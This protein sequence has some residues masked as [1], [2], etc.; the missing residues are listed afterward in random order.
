MSIDH[1]AE[2][3]AR[4]DILTLVRQYVREV[5]QAGK[6]WK[7]LCPFHSEKTPSF[8]ISPD[9]GMAYC[10][11]CHKGGDIFKFIQD[12]ENCSFSEAL[13]ILADKSGVEIVRVSK[14]EIKKMKDEK[15]KVRAAHG[16]V[17]EFFECQLWDSKE[18]KKV[19]QYV[20]GRGVHEE[21]VKEFRLGYAPGGYED[22][23]PKLLKSGFVREDLVNAGLVVVKDTGAK[24]VY[25]RFRQRLMFPIEDAEG[26]IIGFGGRA[27]AAGVD[28]KYVNS[29]DTPV[30]HK[31]RVIYNLGRARAHVRE[32][33]SVIVVEGYMDVLMSHQAGVRNVVASSGTAFTGDQIK[34]LVRLTKNVYF[35]FDADFAG[36]E[37]LR[38]AIAISQDYDMNI[39]VIVIPKGKDP[40]DAVK[41]NPQLWVLAVSSALPYMDFYF[42]RVISTYDSKTPD[43]AR[44]ILAEIMPVLVRVKS[45]IELD[46]YVGQLADRLGVKAASVY[47][48]LKRS[49]SSDDMVR[50]PRNDSDSSGIV[51]ARD[52]RLTTDDYLFGLLLTSESAFEYFN[53]NFAD[54]P[55]IAVSIYKTIKDYYNVPSTD[56]STDLFL[57]LPEDMRDKAHIVALWVEEKTQTFSDALFEKEVMC[58]VRTILKE[59]FSRKKRDLVSELKEARRTGDID[60]EKSLL[61]AYNSLL[62]GQESSQVHLSSDG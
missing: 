33:D 25:D 35:A 24:E 10:F 16:E 58:T 51:S 45:R 34:Q 28:A 20:K 50:Q 43:G 49:R 26:R 17:C 61:T 36:F 37:A 47:D 11:G 14:Q 62:Y 2:I 59:N 55:L 56:R 18:G 29:P 27:L 21:T 23:Y 6:N 57:C 48:E 4:L 39:K 3:K 30:Y 54:L 7:A 53:E 40:A 15:E 38:R 44:S 9:K 32:L 12:Y 31:G 60:R 13:Q 19:L 52:S 41:E 8:V 46:R 5:K 1:V 22:T 42:D